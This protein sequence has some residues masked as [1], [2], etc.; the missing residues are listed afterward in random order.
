LPAGVAE[1]GYVDL[2][3]TVERFERSGVATTGLIA[4]SDDDWDRYESRHWRAVE[5]WFAESPQHPDAEDIRARHELNRGE[6]I[7]TN[8]ALLGW[9]IFVG[10]KS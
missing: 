6:Y 5:E 8:R 4:A 2:E 10:R 7:R 9:A 1:N 3:G